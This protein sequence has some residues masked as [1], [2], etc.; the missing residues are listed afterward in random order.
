MWLTLAVATFVWIA[1]CINGAHAMADAYL[2]WE[3]KR[4]KALVHSLRYMKDYAY[5]GTWEHQLSR[6]RNLAQRGGL[7]K[8][9]M[10][11]KHGRFPKRNEWWGPEK[12]RDEWERAWKQ[13]HPKPVGV[14]S[15]KPPPVSQTH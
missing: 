2:S 7:T 11:A 4:V 1:S 15:T 10:L 3:Q 13:A 14:E 9:E 12:D 8:S 5:R 6:A